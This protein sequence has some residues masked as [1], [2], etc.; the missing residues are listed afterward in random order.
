MDC[1]PAGAVPGNDHS[2]AEVLKLRDSLLDQFF[3]GI[4]KVQA[5]DKRIERDRWKQLLR[6][7]TDT[8]DARMRT[9]SKDRQAFPSHLS[10]QEAFV[11]DERIRL[12]ISRAS[13]LEM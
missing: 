12:P 4:D 11:H 9:G 6:M 3:A 8:H 2:E 10:N 7:P 5:A 1:T 13:A